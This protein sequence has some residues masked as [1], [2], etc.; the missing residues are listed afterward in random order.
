MDVSYEQIV[1][2]FL[3]KIN[4][5]EL[6]ELADDERDDS[7][8][9]FLTKSLY[10]FKRVCNYKLEAT[11]TDDGGFKIVSSNMPEEEIDEVLDILTNGMVVQ[12]LKP[13]LNRQ[14]NLENALSTR[15]FTVFSPANLLLR[16]RE[17]YSNA[18][19]DFENELREYSFSH[20][21]LNKLHL[22]R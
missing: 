19:K 18:K 20:N 11:R 14:E 21:D 3:N 17:T 5:Y 2:A 8:F 15:D 12:W 10:K 13:F 16:V 7:V 9:S 6:L 22:P 4:E 1:G